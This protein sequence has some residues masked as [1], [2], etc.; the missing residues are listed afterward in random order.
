MATNGAISRLEAITKDAWDEIRQRIQQRDNYSMQL[1][2]ALSAVLVAAFSEHGS[3]KVLIL[4]PLV[5]IYFTTLIL[6]SYRLHDILATYLREVVGPDVCFRA[7][8][9]PWKE[10][11]NWYG[12]TTKP[13]IRRTF[14]VTEMWVVIFLAMG[15]LI[16]WDRA[17]KQ[18]NQVIYASCVVYFIAG[19]VATFYSRSTPVLQARN[20]DWPRTV[21]VRYRR[22]VFLDRDGTINSDTHFPHN[23]EALELI[24]GSIDGLKVL[25][26]LSVDIIVVTNQAGIALGL[27]SR[28]QMSA[29]NE[30]LRLRV[31]AEGGRIDA[32]YFCPHLEPRLLRP[33]MTPCKCSKPAPGMLTQ[34]AEDF[35]LDLS[36]SFIIGDKTSDIAAGEKA[37][38]ITILVET[39]KAGQEE[40]ASS[41]EPSFRAKELYAA[42]GIVKAQLDHERTRA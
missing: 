6:Y 38:C 14:F 27:F 37:G 16:W 18:F 28:E 2:I 12:L 9:P 19:V 3:R 4:A 7:G 26:N 17:D 11:E 30:A 24:P 34:A 42:A 10:W 39:G 20:R 1:S 25:A 33:G 32:F 15:H 29:F 5:N 8:I 40:G 22:A 31:E 41:V 35:C 21:G 23:A 36:R 13:G